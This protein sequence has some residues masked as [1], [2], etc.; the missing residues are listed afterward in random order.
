MIKARSSK[1]EDFIE[2]Q[3]VI[4]KLFTPKLIK[5]EASEF[6]FL[7]KMDAGNQILYNIE[8]EYDLKIYFGMQR[9]NHSLKVYCEDA[10]LK[11]I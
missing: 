5:L 8:D 6:R 2:P 1:R 4:S 10:D 7:D 3:R 9:A 11:D